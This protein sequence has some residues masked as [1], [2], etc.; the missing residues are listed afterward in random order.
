MLFIS[1]QQ[2]SQRMS[3]PMPCSHEDFIQPLQSLPLPR[4]EQPSKQNTKHALAWSGPTLQVKPWSDNRDCKNTN[5]YSKFQLTAPQITANCRCS[6]LSI[7]VQQRRSSSYINTFVNICIQLSARAVVGQHVFCYM[8]QKEEPWLFT[9]SQ[10]PVLLEQNGAEE[11]GREQR[12][13]YYWCLFL[14]VSKD[15][16]VTSNSEHMRGV[17]TKEWV[18]ESKRMTEPAK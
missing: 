8:A 17:L 3:H 2:R 9:S 5:G 18:N 10:G 16:F 14:L 11:W 13:G 6:F 7:P 4:T 12:E 1:S 15:S